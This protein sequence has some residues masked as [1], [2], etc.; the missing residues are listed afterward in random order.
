MGGTMG[1]PC[2]KFGDSSV[3]L[4][5]VDSKKW[6]GYQVSD[7][8][9]ML[10]MMVRSCDDNWDDSSVGSHDVRSDGSDNSDGSSDGQQG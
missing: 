4:Q 5:H 9:M 3:Y 7:E 6:L 8:A 1:E 10:V 2:V